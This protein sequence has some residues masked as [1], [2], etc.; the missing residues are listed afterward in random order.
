MVA[1]PLLFESRKVE[2]KDSN[3]EY[4][5]GEFPVPAPEDKCKTEMRCITDE[6]QK[7]LVIG[8][9]TTKTPLEKTNRV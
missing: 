4:D 3:S 8:T 9:D 1:L 5:R 6:E 7:L 2:L